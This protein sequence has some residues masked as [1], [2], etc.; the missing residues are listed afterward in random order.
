MEIWIITH[1]FDLLQT[2]GIVGGL[3]FTAHAAYKDEQARKIGNL[4]AL[5]ERHDYIWSKFFERPQLAR[6]LEIDVDLVRQPISGE[7]WLFTKMLLIHLDTVRRAAKAGMLIE[8][9]G[10]K[11]DI[12]EFLKLPI[13]KAVWERIKPFQDPTFVKLIESA[14]K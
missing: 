14:L 7:E 13:P 10:I 11:R 8:I 2:A 12:R 1:W 4:I 9:N 5:N 3:F 6:I